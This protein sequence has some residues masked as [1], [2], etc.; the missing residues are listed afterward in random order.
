M[1][2]TLPTEAD[3]AEL[4]EW[5]SKDEFHRHLTADHFLPHY[6][7][8][9]KPEKG[10]VF[11]KVHDEAG[12]AFYLRLSNVMRVEVQFPPAPQPERTGHALKEA[13]AFTSIKAK[14]MGYHEM[15]FDSV[16]TPLIWF[17]RKLG[18][19]PIKDHFRVRLF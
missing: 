16:S 3:K 14:G 4:A 12:T 6:D 11:L 15:I 10:L 7:K 2:Y 8:D 19:E 1:Q 5:V 17:F 18:F 13:F 9:G